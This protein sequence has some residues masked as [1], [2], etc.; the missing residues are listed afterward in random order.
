MDKAPISTCCAHGEMGHSL[1]ILMKFD[2]PI[3]AKRDVCSL[4][5]VIHNTHLLGANKCLKNNVIIKSH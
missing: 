1:V 4:N 5:L 3:H 2:V